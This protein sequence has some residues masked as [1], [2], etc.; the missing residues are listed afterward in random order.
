M[1]RNHDIEALL[2]IV[3]EIKELYPHIKVS[4]HIIYGFDGETDQD[5]EKIFRVTDYFDQV[6]FFQI[7][8]SDYLVKKIPNYQYNE[9]EIKR[10][11]QTVFDYYNNKDNFLVYTDHRVIVLKKQFALSADEITSHTF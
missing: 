2:T 4:T 6:Q 1:N 3:K 9:A 5:F 10:K 11:K 7:W 8:K